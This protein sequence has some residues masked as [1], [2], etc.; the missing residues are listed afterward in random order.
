M[1][2]KY[3]GI[4]KPKNANGKLNGTEKLEVCTDLLPTDLEAISPDSVTSSKNVQNISIDEEFS[5]KL[6]ENEDAMK[7]A[8]NDEHESPPFEPIADKSDFLNENSNDSHLSGISG[9]TSRGSLSPKPKDED[10][11]NINQDSI[12]SRVSSSSQASIPAPIVNASNSTEDSST[13]YNEQSADETMKTDENEADKQDLSENNIDLKM[14]VDSSMSCDSDAKA[15]VIITESSND[16]VE[17]KPA[18]QENIA[19]NEEIKTEHNTNTNETQSVDKDSAN[20]DLSKSSISKSDKTSSKSDKHSNS[21]KRSS[22]SHSSHSDKHHSSSS[23]HRSKHKHHD[24]EKE[25]SVERKDK[26]D[27]DKDKDKSKKYKKSR[28]SRDERDDKEREKSRKNEHSK[29]RKDKHESSHSKHGSSSDKHHNGKSKSPRESSKSKSSSS[30]SKSSKKHSD[31]HSSSKHAAEDHKTDK[32]KARKKSKSQDDHSSAKNQKSDYRRS[33]DRDSNDGNGAGSKKHSFSSQSVPNSNKQKENTSDTFPSSNSSNEMSDSTQVKAKELALS[34]T[35]KSENSKQEFNNTTGITEIRK[36]KIASN[37][38]EARKLIKVRRKIERRNQK[39]K[40][41]Q[42][43]SQM[44]QESS[45]INSDTTPKQASSGCDEEECVKEIEEPTKEENVPKKKRLSDTKE[46]SSSDGSQFYGFTDDLKVFYDV[47]TS[48]NSDEMEIAHNLSATSSNEF[49]ESQ[50]Q[51]KQK[52]KEEIME[53]IFGRGVVPSTNSKDGETV[54]NGGF[55][56][57]YCSDYDDD[58]DNMEVSTVETSPKNNEVTNCVNNNVHKRQKLDDSSKSR[59][60]D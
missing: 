15:L 52:S 45:D 9:L 26:T 29:D 16:A 39:Q 12:L 23:S 1:V 32:D 36:P 28:D 21:R 22:N 57:S 8:A 20:S 3:L 54:Q 50:E 14:D 17:E 60:N 38:Y 31:E 5:P 58:Q 7:D 30:H 43:K 56:V 55:Q 4:E 34:T 42:L 41:K 24:K 51:T 27:H 2:Y 10:L 25:R 19:S 11:E 13:K 40:A 46:N 37:I 49:D 59:L 33:T 35:E 6:C 44:S 48:S 47:D 18:V 53:I